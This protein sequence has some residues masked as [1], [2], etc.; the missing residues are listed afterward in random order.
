MGLH[1]TSSE[2]CFVDS[3]RKWLTTIVGPTLLNAEQIVNVDD[4]EAVSYVFNNEQMHRFLIYKLGE[5]HGINQVQRACGVSVLTRMDPGNRWALGMVD[6]LKQYIV[7]GLC[8]PLR[9]YVTG[10]GQI[11]HQMTIQDAAVGPF[12][13]EQDNFR[14]KAIS[15]LLGYAQVW[16]TN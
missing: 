10:T 6:H 15:F 12:M 7:P 1:P 4:Y 9:D 2:I 11:V 3:M 14:S 8:I 13:E 5:A 16:T